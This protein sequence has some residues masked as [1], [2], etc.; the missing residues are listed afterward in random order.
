MLEMGGR[1]AEGGSLGT[2]VGEQVVAVAE[3]V[4]AVLGGQRR[5]ANPEGGGGGG[6]WRCA[7]PPPTHPPQAHACGIGATAPVEICTRIKEHRTRQRAGARP[8]SLTAPRALQI[9]HLTQLRRLK[10][11]RNLFDYIPPALQSLTGL[12]RLRL[13][14]NPRLRSLPGAAQLKG[15]K[16]LQLVLDP[17]PALKEDWAQVQGQCCNVTVSWADDEWDTASPPRA[18]SPKKTCMMLTVPAADD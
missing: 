7:T 18:A 5:T 14:H 2:T 13:C 4:G 11:D 10:L 3:T 16:K 1:E 9:A 6:A 15:Y 17:L 8:A 12:Q